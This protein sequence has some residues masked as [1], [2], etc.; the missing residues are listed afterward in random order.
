MKQI[1]LL[2]FLCLARLAAFATDPILVRSNF[3]ATPQDAEIRTLVE[4]L[5]FLQVID[6]EKATELA[7]F[8]EKKR[9]KSLKIID[10]VSPNVSLTHLENALTYLNGA[11]KEAVLYLQK[12]PKTEWATR[13]SELVL[14]G[15][16]IRFYQGFWAELTRLYRLHPRFTSEIAV[17]DDREIQGFA[18]DQ[19]QVFL[20]FD[21]G[22]TRF[23]QPVCNLLKENN[24]RANFFVLGKNVRENPA[25]FTAL[26]QSG[27]EISLHSETHANLAKMHDFKALQ[28]EV[29]APLTLVREKYN[30]QIDYFR[31]PYGSRDLAALGLIMDTYKKHIL[32]NIDSQDWQAGFT[33]EVMLERVTR[34]VHL[35]HGGIV[36][37]HDSRQKV[38]DVL[39]ELIDHLKASGYRFETGF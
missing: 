13:R 23:T 17:L 26:T 21:D 29:V 20:T 3:K 19:K 11:E 34:L 28:A 14:Q 36:L 18:Y 10:L 37:F 12:T 16:L 25:L 6:Q 4:N 38:V 31:A 8:V 32:W 2:A 5:A 27:N 39:P 24:I 35:Y 7:P 22:P 30:C 15:D 1:F 9:A 33:K